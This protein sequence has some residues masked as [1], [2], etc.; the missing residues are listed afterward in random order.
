MSKR[1]TLF[2]W[3]LPLENTFFCYEAVSE[4]VNK[5]LLCEDK[6]H[7]TE[8]T[9]SGSDILV[10]NKPSWS[11]LSVMHKFVGKTN[12]ILNKFKKTYDFQITCVD[13]WISLNKNN[14]TPT[15]HMFDSMLSC[16]C[17]TICHSVV[18]HLFWIV[19]V[20]KANNYSV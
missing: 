10:P 8:L 17:S 15:S 11:Q 12:N 5:R 16:L 6:I 4:W 3:C 20:K 14:N 19:R 7:S 1:N 2:F 13:N 18:L 9:M